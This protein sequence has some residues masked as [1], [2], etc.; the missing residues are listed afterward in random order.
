MD[1]R[2][3]WAPVPVRRG[4]TKAAFGLLEPCPGQRSH[5][6]PAQRVAPGQFGAG[7][8]DVDPGQAMGRV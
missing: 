5:A 4:H 6:T 7:N 3:R 2:A 8:A 1:D